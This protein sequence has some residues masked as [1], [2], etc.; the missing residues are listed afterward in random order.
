MRTV[1][2]NGKGKPLPDEYKS[3]VDA[4][5]SDIHELDDLL[6]FWSGE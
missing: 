5:I 1:W 6:H 3:Q 2:Y 4:V